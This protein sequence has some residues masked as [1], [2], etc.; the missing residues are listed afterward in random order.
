MKVDV[1]AVG[2]LKRRMK[3]GLALRTHLSEIFFLIFLKTKS[4][5]FNATLAQRI[6]IKENAYSRN[7]T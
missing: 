5:N 6:S 3:T 2:I 1:F 4:E 7:L